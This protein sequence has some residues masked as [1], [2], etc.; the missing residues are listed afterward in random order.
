MEYRAT[1]I[2]L[3]MGIVYSTLEDVANIF[4]L[5]LYGSQDPFHIALTPEDELKL[6]ALREG[7]PTSPSTSLQFSNWIQFFKDVNKNEPCVSFGL[8]D[9]MWPRASFSPHVLGT[10]IPLAWPSL[11]S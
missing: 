11:A 4:H 9:S 3:F 1:H 2:Y 6:E 5:P 10:S 7:A 8:S